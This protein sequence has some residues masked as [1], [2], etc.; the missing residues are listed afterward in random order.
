MQYSSI[1]WT[2]PVAGRNHD[3]ITGE[4]TTSGDRWKIN[5]KRWTGCQS[6]RLVK[7]HAAAAA[8]ATKSLQSCPT[9]WDPIDISPPGFPVPGILQTRTLKWIAIS[10]SN[11]WKW[12]VK[13][14]SLSRVWLFETLWTVAY[15]VPLS[16]G[17]S[18]QKYWS[19]VPLPSPVKM[20]RYDRKLLNYFQKGNKDRFLLCL[21]LPNV[22]VEDP[23]P[24]SACFSNFKLEIIA[25]SHHYFYLTFWYASQQRQMGR[26]VANLKFAWLKI[27]D[28]IS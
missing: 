23:S 10:L 13:V 1:W 4:Y 2:I 25:N 22:W 11:A 12:K 3:S 16:T 21:Y 17:F 14:K 6:W 8:A 28:S 26:L 24:I 18:R 20:H 7:K 19:G 5:A 27:P 15:Q 9:L